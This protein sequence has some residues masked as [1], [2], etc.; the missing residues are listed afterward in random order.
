MT[1]SCAVSSSARVQNTQPTRRPSSSA[2]HAAVRAG[3][4]L[5]AKS[6]TIRATSASKGV[7][8]PISAA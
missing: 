8:H 5:S 2:I 7:P 1:R 6:A 4:G 3:S